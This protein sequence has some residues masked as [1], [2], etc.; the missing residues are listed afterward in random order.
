MTEFD[1]ADLIKGLYEQS[2]KQRR[3]PAR[4]PADTIGR[5]DELPI[6]IQSK[7]AV[8]VLSL[9]VWG[10][11]V[12]TNRV[13]DTFNNNNDRRVDLEDH[14]SDSGHSWRQ[15]TGSLSATTGNWLG[16]AGITFD[17]SNLRCFAQMDTTGSVV[18]VLVA[19]VTGNARV[20]AEALF[21]KGK[22]DLAASATMSP[23]INKVDPPQQILRG[24][25][26]WIVFDDELRG[27]EFI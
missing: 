20:D 24:R 19:S 5:V 8:S 14:V 26:D 13:I 6:S 25:G 12:L 16:F 4:H 9:P 1:I 15:E 3:N 23:E 11:W 2:T 21:I 18:G 7:I 27:G 10:D 22:A 17:D